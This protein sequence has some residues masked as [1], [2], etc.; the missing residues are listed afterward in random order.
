MFAEDLT[1]FFNP[2]EFADVASLAG[3]DVVGF[4]EKEYLVDASGMGSAATRPAFTLPAAFVPPAFAGLPLHFD[5][6]NYAVVSI[7]PHGSTRSISVL[8]LELA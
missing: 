5:G 3:V 4:F 6:V 8:I 7:D 2:G 1:A